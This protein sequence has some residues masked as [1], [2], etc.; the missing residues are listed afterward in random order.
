M[1]ER[2]SKQFK[3]WGKLNR[4][5]LPSP[6]LALQTFYLSV[7][8]P[9]LDA[10]YDLEMSQSQATAPMCNHSVNAATE[11]ACSWTKR[12]GPRGPQACLVP[13]ISRQKGCWEAQA[14]Q[15]GLQG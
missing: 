5:D 6:I 15:D 4:M 8:P 13:T 1:E 12:K 10:L 2:P 11:A 3:K 7:P 14:E 9:C